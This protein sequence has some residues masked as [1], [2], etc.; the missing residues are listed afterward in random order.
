MVGTL[1]FLTDEDRELFKEEPVDFVTTRNTSVLPIWYYDNNGMRRVDPGSEFYFPVWQTSPTFREGD[2]IN[3]NI[4]RANATYA[5][6]EAYSS[7]AIVISEFFREPAG[8]IDSADPLTVFFSLMLSVAKGQKVL[9]DGEPI[10]K[11]V[12]PVFDSFDESRRVGA[13]MSAWIRWSYYFERVLPTTMSGI[14]LVMKDSCGGVYTYIVNGREV[15]KVGEGM[16]TS[17][18]LYELPIS[19]LKYL[20]GNCSRGFA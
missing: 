10:S 12:F 5:T 6:L 17:I 16:C 14:F 2:E 9:Y 11:I 4:I 18:L 1:D 19:G 20:I 3:E 15:A 13:L 8:G 7:E